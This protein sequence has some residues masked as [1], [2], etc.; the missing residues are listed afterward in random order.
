MMSPRSFV[1]RS[2]IPRLL[3]ALTF[4]A[5]PVLAQDKPADKPQDAPPAAER[6]RY[7]PFD[8]KISDCRKQPNRMQM[9]DCV[10][11]H[12]ETRTLF[13][14]NAAQQNDAN[15]ILVA[16]RNM[17]DPGLKI[18]LLG[19]QNAVTIGTYPEEFAR[20]EAFIKTLDIP[21]KT[22]RITYTLIE[23]DSGKRLGVQHFSF[24][25]A[26]GQRFTMKQGSKIPVATGSYDLGKN[27]AQTQFTYLDVGMNFDTT[28]DTIANGVHLKTKV[29]ESSAT[30]DKSIM[31]VSEPLI[32]QSVIEGVSNLVLGKPAIIGAL[33]VPGS[34]RHLDIEVLAELL[35]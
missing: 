7:M 14:T 27:G 12:Y 8:P 24:N 18:F 13:L 19:S 20:I 28:V 25:V 2:F 6:M 3:L 21:R 16:V 23:S 22:Y 9:T 1:T 5:L 34:T 35:P 29:E 33:D 26:A 30:E 10:A 32:R 31:G 4:A 17:F 11:A 15:E